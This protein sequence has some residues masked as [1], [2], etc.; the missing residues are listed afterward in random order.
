MLKYSFCNDYSEGAHHSIL[1]LLLKT[2]ST[3]EGGYGDDSYTIAAKNA[4]RQNLGNSDVDI[5]FVSGGTQANLI[6]LVSMLKPY[7][8]VISAETGH[9]N[10]HETGAIEATGHKINAI[11]SA[12]GK[13]TV[14]GIES[15]VKLHTDEH[16]VKP[17][18]VFI[19]NSTELGTVY[20]KTELKNISDYCRKNR[21]FLYL[22]GARLGS[23]LMSRGVDLDLQDITDLVD[24]F[25][26]GG[27][28]NGALFGEAIVI[29]NPI[30]KEHFRFH[31]KQRGA[32]LAKGRVTGVQFLALFTDGLYFSLAAHANAQ[33]VKLAKGIEE[34]GH[35]FLTEPATNQIFPILPNRIIGKLTPMYG[36]YIWKKIDEHHSAIRLVSSWA[37][38]NDS[39][40]LFLN[41][42]KTLSGML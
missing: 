42:L 26:I 32:L 25:Y 41:D 14:E 38:S 37:T 5:H 8:S 20:S 27:T 12:D 6:A 34:I 10:I 9:I 22:D 16:M 35:R 23:A 31:L 29:V 28:K 4:I 21:L 33:A 24:M 36:F 30:L 13:L 7:E 11:P 3:Q 40:E 2:N 17:K 18:V 1:E 39:V 15:V 19:S